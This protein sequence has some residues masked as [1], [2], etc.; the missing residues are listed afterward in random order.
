MSGTSTMRDH[1]N[2]RQSR[3]IFLSPYFLGGSGGCQT[4]GIAFF[5]G[6]SSRSRRKAM[7]SANSEQSSQKDE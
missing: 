5:K 1:D 4:P 2:G 7:P 3:N 6:R